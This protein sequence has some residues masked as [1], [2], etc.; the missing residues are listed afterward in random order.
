MEDRIKI[1][2]KK[3]SKKR[4][5][6]LKALTTII[7]MV[8]VIT[9]FLWNKYLNKNSLLGKY[10]TRQ[11]QE[12]YLLGTFHKNHFDKWLDYSMEDVLSVL[13][14]IQPDVVFIEAREEVF[15]EYGVIDGPIDMALVYSYC[16][17]NDIPIEM[18]DWWVVDNS[19]KANSTND[20]RDD[21]IFANIDNKLSTVEEG[22]KV[23]VVCGAG[24]FYEQ[25]ERFVNKGYKAQKIKN[26]STYFDGSSEEFQ[27]PTGVE[28]VWKQRSYF[29]AYTFPEIVRQDNTLN[30]DIKAEFAEGDHDAFYNQQLIYLEYFSENKLYK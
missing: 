1:R 20:M 22:S 7:A 9:F 29:Y 6:T 24:H 27:Y 2:A 13:E 12:V 5:I 10:I 23:L 14:N 15:I 16:V 11:E 8:I 18:I 28:D 30:E 21:M 25:S 17:D 3:G 4:Y 26:K 19:F